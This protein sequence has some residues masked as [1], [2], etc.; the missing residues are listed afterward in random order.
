MTKY[1]EVLE[2]LRMGPATAAWLRAWLG[3][4]AAAQLSKLEERKQ[5]VRLLAVKRPSVS[6]TCAVYALAGTTWTHAKRERQ[7]TDRAVQ[8]LQTSNQWLSAA[9]V[10]SLIGCRPGSVQ[11]VLTRLRLDGQAVSRKK[12]RHLVWRWAAYVEE[13]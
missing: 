12:G 4:D 7:V 10:A 3:Y 8:A 2:A 11:G 9:N 1:D 13:G 5:V 6:G